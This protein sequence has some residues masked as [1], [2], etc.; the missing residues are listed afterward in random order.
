MNCLAVF[1]NKQLLR[2]VEVT[3]RCS[4]KNLFSKILKNPQEYTCVGIFF[5][6][7][8]LLKK[9]LRNWYFPMKFEFFINSEFVEHLRTAGSVRRSQQSYKFVF[10]LVTPQNM[11]RYVFIVIKPSNVDIFPFDMLDWQMGMIWVT[12]AFTESTLDTILI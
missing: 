6:I 9:R 3:Q 4:L 8:T 1:T 7:T 2:T 11:L 5:L 12:Q 10:W